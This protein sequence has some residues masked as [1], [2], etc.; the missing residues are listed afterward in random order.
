[1]RSDDRAENVV[2][3]IHAG[4]PVAHGLVD[5]IAKRAR[6]TGDRSH[7]GAQQPH[8]EHV[9]CLAPNVL[10]TH[11]DDAG[12]T[13]PGTGRGGG[14][15]ML[16]RS[17]L[18]DDARLAH[19]DGQQRL[20]QRV[21]DLVR[22]GVVEIFAFEPDLRTTAMLAEPTRVIQRRGPAHVISQQ[23]L[24]L[25]LKGIVLPGLV[26]GPGQ[27]V[28]GPRQRLRHVP[29]TVLAESSTLVR[30]VGVRRLA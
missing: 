1:M 29:P 6:A 26:I 11:V 13:E 7:F 5:R 22:A 16:P 20:P 10:F 25:C 2:R 8:A 17:G 12:Q 19:A 4:H 24:Q 28:Q 15:A 23:R 18:G 27:F 3:V 9:G 30:H 21:V 14:H